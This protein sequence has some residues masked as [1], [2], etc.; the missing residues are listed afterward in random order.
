MNV[1]K[2]IWSSLAFVVLAGVFDMLCFWLVDEYTTSFW[3][4]VA[5]LNGSILVLT[6][7]SLLMAKKGK[8]IYLSFQDGFIISSYTGICVILNLCFAL[9][10]MNNVQANVIVNVIIL[11]IYLIFLFIVFANTAAITAQLEHDRKERNAYY[12]LKDKAERLLGKG[13]SIQLNKRIES[14]YDKICSC[15]I[16]R[17]VD[18]SAIDAQIL[19]ELTELEIE[20]EEGDAGDVITRKITKV[21]VLIED[22][23]R[24]ITNAIKR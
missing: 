15:Q 1:K 3:I 22:R 13:N 19:S 11:A 9:C 5:F 2:I 4:S 23:N 16:N 7:S 17:A 20:L 24:Q 21:M 8:Y 6:L 12:D 14:M 18:V 10:R